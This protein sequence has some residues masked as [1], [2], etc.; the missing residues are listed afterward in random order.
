LSIPFA[1]WKKK[2][3]SLSP[4]GAVE[5]ISLSRILRQVTDAPTVLIGERRHDPDFESQ[6]ECRLND[7]FPIVAVETAMDGSKQIPIA[8]VFKIEEIH[9]QEKEDAYRSGNDT[10]YKDGYEEGKAEGL[11]E[12]RKVLDQFDRAIKEVVEQRAAILEEARHK[13]LDLIV[14]ISRK[15]TFDTIQIDQEAT[16]E[17]ISRVINQLIDK[18]RIKVKV[19]PDHLPL[20]EQSMDKFLS[21][22]SSIKELSIEPD[23]R[24]KYGGCF[25][26]TPTGDI[27]ARVESQFEV[28]D[29]VIRASEDE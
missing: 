15:V 29:G 6:A 26:E 10:G 1:G 17:M 3:R 18:S 4:A 8:E 5:R 19:H 22:S 27:D 28:I 25:I 7:L 21:A 13:V 20:V 9:R 24:V 12:A 11:K 23:P 14:K 16:A 2:A